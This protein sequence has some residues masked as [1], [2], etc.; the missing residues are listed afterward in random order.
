[1]LSSNHAIGLQ[2]DQRRLGSATFDKSSLYT[3]IQDLEYI[4]A[5]RNRWRM[6]VRNMKL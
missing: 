1:M 2:I 6:A 4:C 3:M 5:D